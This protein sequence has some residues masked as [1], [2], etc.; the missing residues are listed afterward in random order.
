M[1][2]LFEGLRIIV[3]QVT[4]TILF[5]KLYF[6][7]Y[8]CWNEVL[9]FLTNKWSYNNETKVDHKTK[10]IEISTFKKRDSLKL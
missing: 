4:L 7:Y 2:D 9:S 5:V 8:Y 3:A 6:F 10:H 1:W